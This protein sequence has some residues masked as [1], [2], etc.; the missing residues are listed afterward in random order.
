[1]N[2]NTFKPS[3]LFYLLFGQVHYLYKGCLVFI[4]I[5]FCRN[6]LN[7]NANSV[8]PNQMPHSAASDLVYTVCQCPFYGMLGLYG[9]IFSSPD[10]VQLF[11]AK[12]L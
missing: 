3:G 11:P 10:C 9:L 5:I 12:L 4:I 6:S 2:F 7:F 1:M 8:D